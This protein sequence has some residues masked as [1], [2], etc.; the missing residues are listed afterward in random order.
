MEVVETTKPPA[1][2][3]STGQLT[4]SGSIPAGALVSA[5]D[6]ATPV[7]HVNTRE[8]LSRARA[9]ARTDN[10]MNKEQRRI[11]AKVGSDLSRPHLPAAVNELKTVATK[12][13]PE[14]SDHMMDWGEDLW[15]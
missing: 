1:R 13:T 9:A 12:K 2:R 14:R 3:A 11:A 7:W 8:H 5:D 15:G 6:D 4:R 10:S